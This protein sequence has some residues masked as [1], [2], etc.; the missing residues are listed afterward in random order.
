MAGLLALAT[1]LYLHHWQSGQSQGK[2]KTALW[3]AA[4]LL[5]VTGASLTKNYF[6]PSKF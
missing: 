1:A 6:W 3:F 2:L 4:T 5:V